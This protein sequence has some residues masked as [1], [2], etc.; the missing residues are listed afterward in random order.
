VRRIDGTMIDFTLSRPPPSN[1]PS[2]DVASR[3]TPCYAPT[4]PHPDTLLSY[5]VL[6]TKLLKSAQSRPSVRMVRLRRYAFV[7]PTGDVHEIRAF[8]TDESAVI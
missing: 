4:P 1:H 2:F 5:I 8:H 7:H 3:S 6:C